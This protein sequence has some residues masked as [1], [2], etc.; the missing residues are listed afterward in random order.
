MKKLE[1]WRNYLWSVLA[2]LL[3]LPLAGAAA[4]SASIPGL[5]GFDDYVAATM[6]QFKVP[7]VSVAI[8]RDGK[9]I[10]SRG[11]GYRDTER[12]LPVTS[13][14]LFAIGSVTKSFSVTMLGTLVDE[15]K[16][17]WDKPVRDYFPAFHMHDSVATE[18]MT[19]RDL[20]T[21]RSGLPRHDLVWYTQDIS[22]EELI[23]RLRYLEPNKPFRS[24]YQYNNL[25]FMTAGYLGGNISGGTWEQAVQ[26]RVLDAIGMPGTNF[27]VTD[28]QKSPDFAQPYRK[29]RKTQLVSKIPFYVQTAVGP[30]GEINSNADDLARYLLFHLN[31]GSIDGKQILSRNNA[32]QMQTPQMA[33][34]GQSPFKEYGGASYGL[35]FDITT[36]RGHA[37]IQH[38][39][40]I[41]GFITSF[42]FLPDDKAGVVVMA[43]LDQTTLPE[44][45]AD[46]VID[47]LLG[48]DPIDWPE[49]FLAI[50]KQGNEAEEAAEHQGYTGQKPGTHPSHELKEY[51]GEFS[52]PA[53]GHVT[54]ALAGGSM[55]HAFQLTL[56]RI[57]RPLDH[58][59]YDT[60]QVPANPKDEFEKLKVTFITDLKG[61]IASLSMPLEPTVEPIV[62]TRVPEKR[63]FDPAFL[64][65]FVGDYDQPV[66]PLTVIL[67]GHA[68]AFA[69]QGRP[70]LAL[71]PDHGTTFRVID[72]PGESVEFKED[73]TGK[74]EGIIIY[75]PDGVAFYKRK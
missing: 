3:A 18:E 55:G 5:S 21:H 49:R 24:A 1:F 64:G 27:S 65:A 23:E 39:G 73:A 72:M 14:T 34:P 11:Y 38:G 50:E 69:S 16:L 32:L 42:K 40:A 56:N 9:I 62:F 46:N 70:K 31:L 68:L 61:D 29:D 35:A 59:H 13:K 26:K 33:I 43:D 53:Y 19:M 60:F 7:G 10:L 75:A 45:I 44:V 54:I 58:F 66:A 6:K 52:H 41:D 20:V 15:G 22:R 51:V 67:D 17:D 4:Q 12:Q 57:I 28:S 63:M 47:R 2:C 8:V 30:A 71:A 36:Y 25:M 48:L 37:V 74:V